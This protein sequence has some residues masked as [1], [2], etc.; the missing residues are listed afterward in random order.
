MGQTL[1]PSFNCSAP[2]STTPIAGLAQLLLRGGVENTQPGFRGIV[3][4][5][6]PWDVHSQDWPQAH[7]SA[8]QEK[9]EEDGGASSCA[10]LS[11]LEAWLASNLKYTLQVKQVWVTSH[12]L[13]LTHL[14]QKMTH[15]LFPLSKENCQ[16]WVKRTKKRERIK[17]KKAF[18]TQVK[19]V[20]V[21]LHMDD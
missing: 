8:T 1:P 4:S 17:K 19:V 6:C 18:D 10:W 3:I 7:C 5:P 9:E 16:W 13:Q 20:A 15:N 21:C 12:Q 2:H 11:L 14:H